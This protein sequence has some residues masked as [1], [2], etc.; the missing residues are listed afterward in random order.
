MNPV[1]WLEAII[2]YGLPTVATFALS[3]VCW[4]MYMYQRDHTI[5]RDVYEKQVDKTLS[6][7]T[8]GQDKII[9]TQGEIVTALELLTEIHRRGAV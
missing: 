6:Q 4:K 8:I 3:W 1:Q 9:E 7:V 5:P 2:Q